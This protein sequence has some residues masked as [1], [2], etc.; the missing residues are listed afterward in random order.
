MRDGALARRLRRMDY[1]SYT[2]TGSRACKISSPAF[3]G[4]RSS[5]VIHQMKRKQTVHTQNLMV[6]HSQVLDMSDQSP[7]Q[8]SSHRPSI[9][10]CRPAQLLECQQVLRPNQRKSTG[11][12][13]RNWSTKDQ[14]LWQEPAARS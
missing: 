12:C 13:G 3:A 2:I 10:V 5:T 8:D 9:Q 6:N 1:P 11:T 7:C 4:K 14:R